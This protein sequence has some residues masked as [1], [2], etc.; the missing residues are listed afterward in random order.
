MQGTIETDELFIFVVHGFVPEFYDGFA[1][2]KDNSKPRRTKDIECPYCGR[3]FDTVEATAKIEVFRCSTKSNVDCH[4]T[5][6][7]KICHRIVGVRYA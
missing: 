2:R 5:R 3:I 7:C 4:N 1:F 6:S